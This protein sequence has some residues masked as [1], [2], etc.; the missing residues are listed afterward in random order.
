MDVE[1]PVGASK[2]EKEYYQRFFTQELEEKETKQYIKEIREQQKE[3]PPLTIGEVTA[4]C[5]KELSK[6]NEI[7]IRLEN[8]LHSLLAQI[9]PMAMALLKHDLRVDLL[10]TRI[11]DLE[12]RPLPQV[13][14]VMA[15]LTHLEHDQGYHQQLLRDNHELLSR[16]VKI[17]EA[18]S[19]NHVIQ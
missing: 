16:R 8:L 5:Q 2:E 9:R 18:N 7:D 19:K 6:Q 13:D 4:I 1:I 11:K 3:L 14:C 15:Q 17:L 12:D 10:E